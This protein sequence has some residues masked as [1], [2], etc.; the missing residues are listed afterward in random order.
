MC[1]LLAIRVSSSI[2][3][4]SVVIG[5]KQER[6][7]F[8]Q[9]RSLLIG[10]WRI[11]LVPAGSDQC[12]LRDSN[13]QKHLLSLVT[14]ATAAFFVLEMVSNPIDVPRCP[15]GTYNERPRRAFA[16]RSPCVTDIGP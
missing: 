6:H 15:S 10:C 16:L 2:H 14:P 5:C 4:T 13:G 12:S 8:G 9:L 11:D 7:T 1:C 3:S